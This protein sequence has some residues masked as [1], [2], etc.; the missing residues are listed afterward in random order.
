M[1]QTSPTAAASGLLPALRPDLQFFPS[2]PRKD[3]SPTFTLHDP[4]TGLYRRIGWGEREVLKRLNRPRRLGDL[5][6]ALR[7]ETTLRLTEG[8]VLQFCQQAGQAGLLRGVRA[9]D[10]TRCWTQSR[11]SR[12]HPLQWL[13]LHYLYV[14]I[15]LC[16]PDRFL[17]RTLS[18]VRPLAAPFAFLLHGAAACL[19]LYLLLNQWPSYWQT[20]LHFFNP[21]GLLLY[22]TIIVLLKVVHEFAHAYTAKAFGVRVPTMGI[23]LMVF[24]PVAFCDVTD[25]WRLPRRRQRFWISFA[26]IAAELVVAAWALVLWGLARPGPWQSIGFLLSSV[27]LASTLLVNLNPAMRFDGYFLLGDVWGVENLQMRAFALT[28]RWLRAV[29]FGLEQTDPEPGSGRRQRAGMILYA[30]YAWTYR[31][32]LYLSIAVLVYAAFAK[33]LGLFLLLVEIGF[34]ILRPLALEVHAMWQLRRSLR[35]NARLLLTVVSV[36]GLAAWLA[37][38]LPR[39]AVAPAVVLPRVVQPLYAPLSGA[40]RDLTCNRLDAVTAGQVL[41]RVEPPAQAEALGIVNAEIGKRQ[42]RLLHCESAPLQAKRAQIPEEREEIR[43]LQAHR[44]ALLEQSRQGLLRADYD[45]VLYDFDPLLREG[46]PVGQGALLGHLADLSALQVLA[47]APEADAPTL[48]PGM[49]VDFLPTGAVQPVASRVTSVHRVEDRD[50][51]HPGLASEWQGSLPVLRSARG[52]LILQGS[53]YRIVVQP[54]S[55]PPGLR[56]GRTGELRFLTPPRSKLQEWGKAA[57]RLFLRES[58]F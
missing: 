12:L 3:G 11:A 50:L 34:F 26:G 47:Y 44:D 48:R 8:D 49:K 27:T 36:A 14:R 22:A 24:W 33:V 37:L 38:P 42:V 20:F 31:F 17:Q 15:P 54:V 51:R 2:A 25:G 9:D 43:R 56:I 1:D 52:E 32:A 58:N 13:L 40:V 29:C 46:L 55:S 6:S 4:L 35:L 10:A 18:W 53:Y 7:R 16:H 19:G 28:R 5:L 41:L 39:Q 21:R 30:L 45:G 23:A 57:W